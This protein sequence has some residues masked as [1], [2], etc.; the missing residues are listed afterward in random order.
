[1]SVGAFRATASATLPIMKRVVPL[2]DLVEVSRVPCRA[3]IAFIHE[4]L[5]ERLTPG[6]RGYS[7]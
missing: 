1:M 4:F 2:R 7:F 6:N 3:E 5:E